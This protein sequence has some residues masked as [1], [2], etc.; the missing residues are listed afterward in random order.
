MRLIDR[1]EVVCPGNSTT[2]GPEAMHQLV[3]ALRGLGHEARIVYFPFDRQFARP[4]AYAGYDAPQGAPTDRPSTLVIL[5][6]NKI[7]F[8]R[9]FTSAQIAVWWLSVDNYLGAK[10]ESRA[11]DVQ[12]L[13][14][15]VV[16]RRHVPMRA[17]R[18]YR[19]FVQSHYAA[20]FLARHGLRSEFLMDYLG[21][22]H[23]NVGGRA[24]RR[25]IVVYNPN[26][27]RRR[28]EMLRRDN[29]GIAFEPI[30]NLS[31]DG[32]ARL[33]GD[34]KIYADFGHHPGKDR[35]PREAAMAGCCVITGRRG[36][37][38]FSGD[39]PIPERYK[40]DDGAPGF[41]SAFG[42]L[43]AEI[44]FDFDGHVSDFAEYRA[45][46]AG[47]KTRFLGQVADAFGA[48]ADTG[49]QTRMLRE[50]AM[51]ERTGGAA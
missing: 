29:P 32:V 8:A 25:D 35:M 21:D 18:G 41:T 16:K 31:S 6:E 34:A 19:H 20:D 48:A 7:H 44:F 5:P 47:E 43:A 36:S 37:A 11:S 46:I 9:D 24:G 51:T 23:T 50:A 27:G 39:V 4:D 49:S 42:A 22:A 33:L 3:D 1:I 38:A 15:A 17:M 40:L 30:A 26:K 10:H 28:I 12:R 14:K 2:G 45:R 13:F